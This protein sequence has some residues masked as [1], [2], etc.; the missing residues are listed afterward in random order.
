MKNS[1][2]LYRA[3]ITVAIAALLIVMALS[4]F[5]VDIAV[6]TVVT[7]LGFIDI[8]AAAI[9]YPFTKAKVPISKS[10]WYGVY[11]FCKVICAV[12][13]VITIGTIALKYEVNLIAFIVIIQIPPAIYMYIYQKHINTVTDK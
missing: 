2:V 8:T 12:L 7:I 5:K 1:A 11:K 6:I 10:F 13:P 4:L 3:S 9:S